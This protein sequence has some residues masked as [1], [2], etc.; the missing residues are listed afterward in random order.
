MNLTPCPS[1]PN[2]VTSVPGHACRNRTLPPLR[3]TGDPENAL[4]ALK[5]SVQAMEGAAFVSRDGP[6][7]RFTFTSKLFGFVDDVEFL[8][9]PE[10]SVIHFRSASRLGYWDLG[11]NRARMESVTA[12]FGA[13]MAGRND[14]E[15]WRG[16]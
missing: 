8:L 16:Y 2:C 14:A 6:H 5:R 12:R 13:E 3:F 4:E 1:S 15:H 9:A 11:T 7:L 10:E